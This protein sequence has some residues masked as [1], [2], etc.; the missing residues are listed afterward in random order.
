MH[1]APLFQGRRDLLQVNHQ[2]GARAGQYCS[3]PR[4]FLGIALNNGPDPDVLKVANRVQ[5]LA[6]AN[7][8]S[9]STRQNHCDEVLAARFALV[10]RA[11]HYRLLM[12]PE[13]VGGIDESDVRKSL[14]KISQ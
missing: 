9:D 10:A 3:Q 4:N 2:L 11:R 13:V 1:G 5:T 6:R 12:L 14:G 8:I 7:L